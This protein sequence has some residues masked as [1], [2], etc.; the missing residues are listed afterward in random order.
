MVMSHMLA[1]TPRELHAMADRI[2]MARR[3]FQPASSPHYDVSQKRRLL[4]IAAGAV[5]LD[6]RGIVDLVR[7]IRLAPEV[8]WSPWAEGSR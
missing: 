6:R 1:D 4:A 5:V 3:W 8:D 2:G 7:R